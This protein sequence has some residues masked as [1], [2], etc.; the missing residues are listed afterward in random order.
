MACYNF[1]LARSS[2]PTAH[3][4]PA[5]MTNG[6]ESI[7]VVTDTAR[8]DMNTLPCVLDPADATLDANM[9]AHSDWVRT[10]SVIGDGAGANLEK[11][12]T[13]VFVSALKG[14]KQS[15]DSCSPPTCFAARADGASHVY[16]NC[17]IDANKALAE[18]GTFRDHREIVQAC[19]SNTTWRRE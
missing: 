10:S 2:D 4:V 1:E 3:A 9:C 7:Y 12:R 8:P 17:V 5:K 6:T 18:D 19:V 13:R 11:D 14:T 16:E 15:C